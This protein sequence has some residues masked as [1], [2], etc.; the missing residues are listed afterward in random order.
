MTTTPAPRSNVDSH[1]AAQTQS[2]LYNQ[3]QREQQDT[4]LV[5]KVSQLEA[6]VHQQNELIEKNEK[7]LYNAEM[8]VQSLER[9]V[10]AERKRVIYT[11]MI[12]ETLLRFMGH[13]HRYRI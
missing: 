6:V 9:Q 1:P 5:E 13:S 11:P 12:P 4:K 3:E 7:S 10:E 8:Q 2:D